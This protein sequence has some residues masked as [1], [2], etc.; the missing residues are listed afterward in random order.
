MRQPGCC[1]KCPRC[2]TCPAVPRVPNLLGQ[3]KSLIPM[4][5]IY[6]VGDCPTV[7]TF[8]PAFTLNHPLPQVVLTS[9]VRLVV[10]EW[11]R[12]KADRPQGNYIMYIA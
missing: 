3:F 4:H 1:P 9:L 5:L 7:P 12:M 11:N 2:P 10:K 8:F 6:E